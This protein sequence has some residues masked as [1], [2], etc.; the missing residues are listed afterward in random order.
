VA[1]VVASITTISSGMLL[2]IKHFTELAITMSSVS[3]PAVFV[4]CKEI[5]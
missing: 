1:A 5:G 2:S 3:K 4:V